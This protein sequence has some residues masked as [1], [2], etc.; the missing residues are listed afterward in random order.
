MVISVNRSNQHHQGLKILGL[1]IMAV[2][3]IMAIL[4][5]LSNLGTPGY[6]S[7]LGCGI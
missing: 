4:A 2:M 7:V 5:M 1:P 3:A 6:H